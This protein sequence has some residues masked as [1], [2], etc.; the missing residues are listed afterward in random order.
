LG[1]VSTYRIGRTWIS[2]TICFDSDFGLV[3]LV[4]FASS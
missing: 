2:F 1:D 3:N 4:P